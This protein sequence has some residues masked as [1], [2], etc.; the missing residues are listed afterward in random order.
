MS[1]LRRRP[2][3]RL[4]ALG[5]TA[6]IVFCLAPAHAAQP[7]EQKGRLCAPAAEMSVLSGA[8]AA[9]G[10]LD[11]PGAAD[12]FVAVRRDRD[13]LRLES[14]A[15]GI[16]VTASF[17]AGAQSEACKI[18]PKDQTLAWAGAIPMTY[19]A[20]FAQVLRYRTAHPPIDGANLT[21]IETLASMAAY[22]PYVLISLWTLPPG[23]MV[24]LSCSGGEYYRVDPGTNGVLPFD[25]CVEGHKRV[26][27]G[28]SQ[29]PGV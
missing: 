28:L 21:K 4:S 7:L 6:S 20:S 3:S 22:G 9:G 25:G 18:F 12:A 15:L 16:D 8:L 17:A 27:P 11:K 19:V 2:A 24:T 14:P 26:L 13:D 10:Y 5:L 23:P 29:L 1:S